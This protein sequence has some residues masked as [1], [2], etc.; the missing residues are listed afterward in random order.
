MRF[1]RSEFLRGLD[2]VSDEDAH[3]CLTP[4]NCLS[5]DLGHTGLPE[6]VGDID[7]EATYSPDR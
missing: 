6:F 3:R 2:G 5:W 1:T 7:R 4:M